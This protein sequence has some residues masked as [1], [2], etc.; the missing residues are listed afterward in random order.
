MKKDSNSEWYV[1][2]NP[3]AGNNKT[4]ADWPDIRKLLEAEGFNMECVFTEYQYHATKLVKKAVQKNGVRKIIVVGGD[5]T[6]NEV[7]NGVFSQNTVS[8]TDIAIGVI[9]VGTGN[10]W[11][12]MYGIPQ[13]Y[14]EQIKIIK[15]N[16]TFLQDVGKVKYLH[17]NKEKTHYFINIAGMGFDALVAKK[18]NIAK[19]KGAGGAFSYM[20]NLITGLFQFTYNFIEIDTENERIFSG[21]VFSMSV[22]ICKYNGGGM[23]QLP[24]AKPDDGLFDV[25]VIRKVSRLKVLRNIKNLYDGSFI[26][27]KEVETFTG[28]QFTVT[29]VPKKSVF[30]ETDGESLGH[31]PLHFTLL[32]L[33]AKVII[34]ENP[35]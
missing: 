26:K 5:G 32:P 10:D 7:L 14:L 1:V 13:D 3:Q 25:T 19:Q 21:K 34:K 31:S 24:F 8:T 29:A 30:L 35:N 4:R 2:V 23:M 11:G 27:I 12:R 15:H 22:G 6:L 20:F 17:H 28:N 18:S 33:A 16:N 9:T